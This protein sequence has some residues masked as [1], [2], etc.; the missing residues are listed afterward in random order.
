MNE[1]KAERSKFIQDVLRV[2]VVGA[3]SVAPLIPHL[4]TQK[5][6]AETGPFK[7]EPILQM[8]N[9]DRPEFVQRALWNIGR[10]WPGNYISPKLLIEATDK[11]N[12]PLVL[13]TTFESDGISSACVSE[14]HDSPDCE[15]VTQ[16]KSVVSRYFFN[17][18]FL[19]PVHLSA[20]VGSGIL[21]LPNQPGGRF[22]ITMELKVDDQTIPDEQGRPLIASANTEIEVLRP[23]QEFVPLII[24]GNRFSAN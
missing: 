23:F 14:D 24:K 2:L 4:G 1:R 5:T 8:S 7:T 19:D 10:V 20:E 22:T 15:K 12:L 9:P 13:T 17:S 6:N 21:R 16:D 18:A 3:I 11:S